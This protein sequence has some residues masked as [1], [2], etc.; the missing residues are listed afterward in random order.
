M[1]DGSPRGQLEFLGLDEARR[2]A[3]VAGATPTE[4]RRL[5]GRLEAAHEIMGA[6][7]TPEELAF[8]HAGLCQTFLP[9]ARPAAD[10]A[11]WERSAGR[12]HLM[13]SPGVMRGGDGKAVRVGVPYGP[14]ARL[15]L[16]YLQS[17]GVKGRTVPLGRTMSAWIRSLGLAV[18][19]GPRGT[20][21]AVREQALRIARCSF[22][23]QWDETDAAGGTRTQVRDTQ[24]V[25]GLDLWTEPG[26]DGARWPEAV[27]LTERFYQHLKDHAVPLDRRAIA[28]LSDNSLG[29]DLY[30]L[31]AHRLPRL[32]VDLHLRWETL[33]DQLGSSQANVWTLAQRI[34]GVLPDV[35]AVYP[36]ARVGTTR[37]GLLLS[38]SPPSV[39]RMMVN[40]FRRVERA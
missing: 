23:L 22:T 12:F 9:H 28:H 11:I 5:R 30:A 31:F 13:V 18:T 34:R 25:D 20:I 27:E 24:I 21:G 19:G 6:Q 29:L 33:R 39:P 16:I 1:D 17:E 15:I 36:D 3:D 37:H 40:G 2:R 14:K 32:K 10:D 4:R 8:L 38:P 7:P 35:V 26:D